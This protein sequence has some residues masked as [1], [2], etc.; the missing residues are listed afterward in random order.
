[1]HTPDILPGR[2]TPWTRVLAAMFLVAVIFP[3][4]D[5]FYKW[6]TGRMRLSSWPASW[7]ET[8]FVILALAFTLPAVTYIA[9]VGRMP[10][11]WERIEARAKADNRP[12]SPIWRR[13]SG[14]FL[15]EWLRRVTILFLGGMVIRYAVMITLGERKPILLA[16]VWCLGFAVLVALTRY[17]R[18]PAKRAPADHAK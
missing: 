16:L 5:L 2:I 7:Y 4:I 15:P 18:I 12:G 14:Q 11:Y 17:W 8:S 10:R 6:I 13:S 1:M 9:F 3:F